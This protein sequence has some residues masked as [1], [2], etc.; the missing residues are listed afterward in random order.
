MAPRVLPKRCQF[1][2]K[3]FATQR[4]I[5][6]HISASKIC[7]KGWHKNIVKKNDNPLK[8]RR[9]D[10]PEPSLD[11]DDNFDPSPEPRQGT[12]SQHVNAD[13]DDEAGDNQRFI[14]PFPGVAGEAL[15]QEKTRFEILEQTHQLEGGNPWAPFANKAEWGLVEWLM[16]NVGQK[17]TDEYLRLPIV[18]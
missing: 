1:C 8:R 17:S 14:E 5:N 2:Q 3:A 13:D 11:N 15:R 12:P 6:Q 10:S 7:L 4:A 9:T 18:S 16:K